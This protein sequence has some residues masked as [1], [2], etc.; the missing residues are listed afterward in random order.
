MKEIGHQDLPG[1]AYS[2]QLPRSAAQRIAMQRSYY[3]YLLT[4]IQ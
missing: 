4:Y 2:P 3:S 1:P